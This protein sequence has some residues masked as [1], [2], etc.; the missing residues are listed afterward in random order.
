M[1][2]L[3]VVKNPRQMLAAGFGGA[4]GSA[5]DIGTLILLKEWAHM[6][7]PIAAFIADA[8]T[9]ST[10]EL[11]RATGGLSV[12]WLSNQ[13][14]ALAGDHGVSIVELTGSAVPLA[15]AEQLAIPRHRP[16]CTPPDPIDDTPP[17]ED[18]SDSP[19]PSKN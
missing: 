13:K 10:R 5:F 1:L 8:A 14:L 2:F 6:S 15:G 11:E 12:E 7:T 16:R 9:G 4:V 3:P 17:D 19:D 18:P